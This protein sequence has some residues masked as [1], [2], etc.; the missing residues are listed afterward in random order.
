[1]ADWHEIISIVISSLAVVGITALMAFGRKFL[2]VPKQVIIITAA[3]YR[4]LRSNKYQG[5]ALQKIAVALKNGSTNGEADEAVKAVLTDQERTDE[6]LRRAA[7]AR[8]DNLADLFK[9]DDE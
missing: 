1:V 4:I 6:F 9:E 2:D 3:L 5:V 8:P 7:L